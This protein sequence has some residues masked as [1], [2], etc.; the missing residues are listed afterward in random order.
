MFRTL[1]KTTISVWILLLSLLASCRDSAV[2]DLSPRQTRAPGFVYLEDGRFMVDDSVWFPLM[3]NYKLDIRNSEPY[4]ASYY[5]GGSFDEHFSQIAEWGF[6][7]VR[8]CMDVISE[9]E[10]TA[11]LFDGAKRM[12]DTAAAHGLRVMLLV[13]APFDGYWKDYTIGLLRH[14]ATDSDI[15][16]FDLMNEPLYFD[17]QPDREKMDAIGIVSK[18]REMMERYAPHHL[19]TVALAEPIEVFEW[20]PSLLPVDFLEMHTY[21]P[22]R[23]A[24]EM[25]WYGHYTGRPWMVGETGLP[26]DNDSVPYEWQG[27]FMEESFRC[28]RANG[29]IGYGW[30]EFGD[31]LDGTNFEAWFTGLRDSQGKEKPA[32][33]KVSEL[34]WQPLPHPAELPTNYFNMLGYSNLT[35]SGEVVDS[36]SGKPIEGAV[37]RGWNEWWD[38]GMNTYTH[39]N[40]RFNLVSNDMCVHFEISA[41]GYTVTKLDIKPKYKSEPDTSLLSNRLLEY[42]KIDYRPFLIDPDSSIL[43]LNPARFAIRPIAEGDLGTIKLAPIQQKR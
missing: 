23:V 6:N 2:I 1:R 33:K 20:D 4:P 16:A 27:R 29:A 21:N 8:L 38:V 15:F 3:L 24:S 42:Q 19:F 28:A 14:F 26:A 35:V 17:P 12:I 18:W 32:T 25:Y 40:G 37:V 5:G 13:K 39:P 41:P 7:T 31:F 10:D 30:W 11:R 43:T 9:G 22:L 34:L 36:L